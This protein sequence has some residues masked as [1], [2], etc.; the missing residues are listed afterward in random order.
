VFDSLLFANTLGNVSSGSPATVN[1]G[2]LMR[3]ALTDAT[4]NNRNIK[5][6]YFVADQPVTIFTGLQQDTVNN[7]YYLF[8]LE[9][10]EEGLGYEF[11]PV[12]ITLETGDWMILTSHT[13][14]GALN[15]SSNPD[16]VS[17]AVVN[18]TYELASSS[19]DGIVRLSNT[20]TISS[21]TTGNEVIT[22]G[23][24]GSLIGTAANTIAAGNDSRFT[25]ARTPTA[26]THVKEDITGLQTALDSKISSDEKGSANGVASLDANSKI[27]IGY[28]PNEVFDSLSFSS[29]I[30]N[31]DNDLFA[32]TLQTALNNLD[33]IVQGAD[34]YRALRG[35]YF[36][37]SF[38]IEIEEEEGIQTTV[39][40][41]LFGGGGTGYN[42]WAWTFA[43]G[44]DYTPSRTSSGLLE[45]GDWIVIQE[46]S[47]FGSSD[48]P[49][50]VVFG[51]VNNTYELADETVHGIV[52]LSNIT[53]VSSSTTGNQVVTQGVLGSLIG[54]AANTIAAGVHTH[55]ISEIT[56]LQTSLD[57]K[58]NTSNIFTETQ[59]ATLTREPG[60]V[61]GAYNET[62]RVITWYFGV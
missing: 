55:A 58:L 46:I 32:N 9:P 23:V 6:F 31:S 43:T 12:T 33:F 54:T 35:K 59:F 50:R 48:N 40:G 53:S 18:N 25:D 5:G 44:D 4:N 30:N 41:D 51:V 29:T 3:V 8:T 10:A 38:S 62:T 21:S 7:I 52:K 56:N 16:I 22:Q 49:Y 36:V 27:P 19:V 17:F 61:Y 47:G 42:Y 57:A 14:Q 15:S 60:V 13:V 39:L 1:L 34:S 11:N 37:A 2:T 20:T 24:L 28:L 45:A 26:H